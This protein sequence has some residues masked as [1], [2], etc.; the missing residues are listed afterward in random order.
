[1]LYVE[2]CGKLPRS[3]RERPSNSDEAANEDGTTSE[4]MPGGSNGGGLGSMQVTG[5]LGS[6]MNESSSVSLTYAR[7]F[8]R[9][10]DPANSF[11]D[12]ARIH[13]NVPEGSVPKDGPSAGVTMATAL[14]SLALNRS[15]L[16]NVAMTGELTLTGKV[17]KVGGI[18]E[19]VIGARREGVQTLILPKHNEAEYSDLKEYLRAGLT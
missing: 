13:L 15:L 7:L 19:K 17:L 8:A 2:A 18:K 3:H 1:M 6:V 5:Q 16:P 10:L 12:E 4:T 9:E 11:L 14:I